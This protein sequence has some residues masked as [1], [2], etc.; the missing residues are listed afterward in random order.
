MKLIIKMG[1]N[2][3]V[4]PGIFDSSLFVYL[5]ITYLSI[6]LFIYVFVYL[7]IYFLHLESMLIRKH[8]ERAHFGDARAICFLIYLVIYF[9]IRTI[10][11]KC[12]MSGKMSER[13]FWVVKFPCKMSVE[14]N[15]SLRKEWNI[16]IKITTFT[17]F[18]VVFHSKTCCPSFNSLN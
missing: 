13:S 18:R 2:I 11:S 8:P 6:Y 4:T 14:V 3:L 7:F 17:P 5:F 12:K 10:L 9:T 15:F 1:W 16:V